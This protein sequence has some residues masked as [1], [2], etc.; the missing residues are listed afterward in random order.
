MCITVDVVTID[1]EGPIPVYIQIA[2]IISEQIRTG[3]LQPGRVIPSEKDLVDTYGVARTTARRAIKYLRD[4]GLIFTV[5][6]RG[7]YVKTDK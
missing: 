1:H 7:S 3:K 5:P 2:E 4:Q 6:G